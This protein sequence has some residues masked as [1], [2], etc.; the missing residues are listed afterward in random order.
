LRGS[1]DRAAAVTTPTATA[2]VQERCRVRDINQGKRTP[3][4]F[5][6]APPGARRR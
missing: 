3:T 5:V 6:A 1:I 4:S 2:A